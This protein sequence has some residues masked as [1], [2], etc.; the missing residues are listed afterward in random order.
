MLASHGLLH[1]PPGQRVAYAAIHFWLLFTQLM[2]AATVSS[3]SSNSTTSAS[4]EQPPLQAPPPLPLLMDTA[5]TNCGDEDSPRWRPVCATANGVDYV[6][7]GSE[8]LLRQTNRERHHSYTGDAKPGEF[9]PPVQHEL[10]VPLCR[11]INVLVSEIACIVVTSALFIF[12]SHFPFSL[13]IS[14]FVVFL[15]FNILCEKFLGKLRWDSAGRA[16][17]L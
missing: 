13:N 8:C 16:A 11:A 9:H 12:F 7:F 2:S 5:L 15:I 10:Y 4:S 6:L 1:V 17:A 3:S 14:I